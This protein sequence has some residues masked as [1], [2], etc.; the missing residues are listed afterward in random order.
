MRGRYNFRD[1]LA[2]AEF[3]ALWSAEVISVCGDQLARVALSVLVFERTSSAALTALTYALTFVPAVLGGALLAGLADRFPR[4][5]VL[6][7]ADV[8]RAGLA[9]LMALPWMPL[10][11]LWTLVFGLA[12][13]G[14]LSRL[15]SLHCCQTSW[16]VS[17]IPWV[18][19]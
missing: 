8:V 3:R 2:V 1:A 15:P 11:I 9:G 6:V 14:G 4:R 5:A 13:I 16:V 18:W 12:L 19:R 17:A 7:T 10:P